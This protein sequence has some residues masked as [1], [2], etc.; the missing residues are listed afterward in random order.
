MSSNYRLH[1][2]F[3]EIVEHARYVGVDIS[4]DLSLNTHINRI[5][6]N[7]NKSLCFIPRNMQFQ[8]VN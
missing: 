8:N 4:T 3:A 5:T 2:Q 7:A 1:G 6:T